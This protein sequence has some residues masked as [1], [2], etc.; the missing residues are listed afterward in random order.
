[1]ADVKTES[2]PEKK[3]SGLDTRVAIASALVAIIAVFFA[4]KQYHVTNQQNV[5]AEEDQL[6]ALTTSIAQQLDQ[7]TP[8]TAA[9]SITVTDDLEL[10][11]QSAETVISELGGNRVTGIEYLEVARALTRGG[12]ATEAIHY[13]QDAEGAPPHDVSV[14]VAAMRLEGDF[15]Y[16]LGQPVTGHSD[17]MQ[18][19]QLYLGSQV[20]MST[21]IKDNDIAQAYLD[22]AAN[23]LDRQPDINSCSTVN[24]D[25]MD[26][27]NLLSQAG[28]DSPTNQSYLPEEQ[29]RYSLS[30]S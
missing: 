23:Q 26:A 8:S 28:G 21:H 5:A 2:P 30:C 1:M 7:A 19:I 16:T 24:T 25:I 10:D 9:A 11:A 13:F 6:L 12:D 20:V 15:Y 27:K 29:T 17:I 14:E 4:Y 18:S 22:D 3:K